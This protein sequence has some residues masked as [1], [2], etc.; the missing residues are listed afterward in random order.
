MVCAGNCA[1][2]RDR[3][4]CAAFQSFFDPHATA[5]ALI[6]QYLFSVIY[7][8]LIGIP[9]CLVLPRI[10]VRTSRYSVGWKSGL[11]GSIVVLANVVG[12][13]FAGMVLRPIVGATYRFWPEFRNSLGL[14]LVLSAI[15]VAFVSLYEIQESK[16][17]NTAMQ[18]KTKELERERALKLATEARLSML[19]ARIHPHFLFNTLNSISSLIHEDPLRA[20]RILTQ[21][22]ELLRFSLDTAVGGPLERELQI[23]EDYLR[24]RKGQVRGTPA[25]RD[26]HSSRT[27]HGPGATTFAADLGG[28]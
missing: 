7:S 10:W 12:C 19:A 28:E 27:V 25:I 15:I 14:S 20:E 21:L 18:V 1:G 4:G 13:L 3:G 22:A 11:R 9:L 23:V 24:D 16:L 6:R 26:H 17:K 5:P 8:N 2:C